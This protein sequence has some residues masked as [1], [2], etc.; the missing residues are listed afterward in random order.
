MSKNDFVHVCVRACMRV[1]VFPV[2]IA[3]SLPLH[4]DSTQVFYLLLFQLDSADLIYQLLWQLRW[5]LYEG[6][7]P[8]WGGVWVRGGVYF[9]FFG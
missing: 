2:L 7:E 8:V 4:S 9:I 1:C 6:A 5:G 3:F